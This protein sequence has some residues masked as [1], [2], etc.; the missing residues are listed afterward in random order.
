MQPTDTA[1]AKN[2]PHTHGAQ[3]IPLNTLAIAFGLAGL[4]TIWTTAARL[5]GVSEI[6]GQVIW[7]GVVVAWLWLIVAHL[8]RGTRSAETLG[9]QLAASCAGADRRAG[10]CRRNAHRG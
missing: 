4:A 1:T 7:A 3:R 10:P 5:L 9:Q 6:V 2:T 8:R